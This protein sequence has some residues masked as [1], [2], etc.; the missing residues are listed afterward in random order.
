MKTGD[1]VLVKFPFTNLKNQKKRPAL[2]LNT[3]HYAKSLDLVIV[4]MITSKLDG[5]S[6]EGD[7][8]MTDWKESNLLHPSL[9]RLSKIATLDSDLIEKQLGALTLKDEKKVRQSFQK[10]FA[11]WQK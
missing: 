7:V 3:T 5:L 6:L 4:A 2:V 9:V 11:A 8:Q 1:I 10:L